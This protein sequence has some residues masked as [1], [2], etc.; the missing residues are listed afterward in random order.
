MEMGALTHADPQVMRE[1]AQRYGQRPHPE[2]IGELQER[3]GVR[4]QHR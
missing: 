2:L 1:I 3:H 4:L